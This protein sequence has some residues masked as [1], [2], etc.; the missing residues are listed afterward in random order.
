[1]YQDLCITTLNTF[2]ESLTDVMGLRPNTEDDNPDARVKLDLAD[3]PVAPTPSVGASATQTGEDK[4]DAAA[5]VSEGQT[6]HAGDTATGE[7]VERLEP[8]DTAPTTSISLATSSFLSSWL[9]SVVP[10]NTVKTVRPSRFIQSMACKCELWLL[11]K[12]AKDATT[13]SAFELVKATYRSTVNEKAKPFRFTLGGRVSLVPSSSSYEIAHIGNVTL[14]VDGEQNSENTIHPYIGWALP[15]SDDDSESTL[16]FQTVTDKIK[17]GTGSTAHDI[18]VTCYQ[19]VPKS[20]E[21]GTL[22]MPNVLIRPKLQ[23]ELRCGGKAPKKR[24]AV[25]LT[26]AVLNAVCQN[27]GE[28]V[29]KPV[30]FLRT[31]KHDTSQTIDKFK[32]W[33]DGL[34]FLVASVSV[35][36]A[37]NEPF[38]EY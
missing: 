15:S 16:S 2:L 1:M 35:H 37:S 6:P 8:V 28:E 4:P 17:M 26:D 5:Q 18:E 38:I 32:H 30:K 33:P 11:E 12:A 31:R 10:S 25:T 14:Y 23:S 36:D 7:L 19:L 9:P 21:D 20:S 29:Q 34:K 13:H 24:K 3:A 22:M 27:S